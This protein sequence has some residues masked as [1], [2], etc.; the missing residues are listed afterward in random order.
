MTSTPRKRYASRSPENPRYAKR[1]ANSSPEEGEVDDSAPSVPPPPT[2][3]KSVIAPIP[4]PPKPT[5]TGLSVLGAAKKVPFPFKKKIEL[6]ARDGPSNEIQERNVFAKLEEKIEKDDRRAR[7]LKQEEQSRRQQRSPPPLPP[8]VSLLSRI[9]PSADVRYRP[10]WDNRDSRD[11]RDNRDSFN[12]REG[13]YYRPSSPA[14]SPRRNS[15]SPSPHSRGG[16]R[17]RLPPAASPSPPSYRRDRSRERNRDYYD[18]R[19]DEPRGRDYRDRDDRRDDRW[20]SRRDNYDSFDRKMYNSGDSHRYESDRYRSGHRRASPRALSPRS[21]RAT[22]PSPPRRPLSEELPISSLPPRPPSLPPSPP[23]P[24]PAISISK[25]SPPSRSRTPVPPLAP[26]S[27][28]PPADAGPRPPSSTPPPAPPPDTR[29]HPASHLPPPPPG[30]KKPSAPKADHSPKSLDLPPVSTGRAMANGPQMKLSRTNQPPPAKEARPEPARLKKK[31]PLRRPQK[32][33][34]A[35]YGHTFVGCGLQSDYEATTKLGEGT[36]GEVHKAIHKST[37]T[38]VALKRILMHNEKEGMPVTALREIKILKAL[39]HPCIVNILDMFVVRSTEK[40]PLSV[41]MV[42]PYM[43]HDLAGLLENERVKLQPS[44]IKLYMKQLLEGTEYMHR[45]HILHRDMKAANLLISNDGSLRIADFGLARSFDSSPVTTRPDGSIRR[46]RKYTNCVVTRWY[47]PPELLLGARQYGGEVDIWGIGCV[48]GEMFTRRPILPGTS[49]IDQLEKIWY[50]CGSPNQL[51]W[52][53]FDQLP[54]CEGVRRFAN[55][56]RRLKTHYDSIGIPPETVDLLDKLLIINPS[57]RITASQALD[58]DYFWTDPLPADP[59]TMPSYEASHEF[60]KRGHRNQMPPAAVAQI[61]Q[62]NQQQQRNMPGNAA[63]NNNRNNHKGPPPQHFGGPPGGPGDMNRR[64]PPPGAFGVPPPHQLQ[65]HGLPPPPHNMP[66][67]PG[68]GGGFRNGP[69]PYGG[70][71]MHPGGPVPPFMN[72]PPPNPMSGPFGGIGGGGLGGGYG[73]PPFP[74]HP[75]NQFV[76][77]LPHGS[78]PYG[79]MPGN[80][81]G[82][83]GGG[84]RGDRRDGGQRNNYDRMHN[85]NNN[86]NNNQPQRTLPVNPSLPPKPAVPL[87]PMHNERQREREKGGGGGGGGGGGQWGDTGGGWGTGRG[88]PPPPPAD[89]NSGADGVPPGGLN[90]D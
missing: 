9:G 50:L 12:T 64:G 18:R 77:P 48:L 27:P 24:P 21:P 58:H 87:G 29:L 67:G 55:H 5:A 31:L 59:K 66:P 71:P 46:E 70:P 60:D 19:H 79:V 40:D 33:E 6:H 54:G 85:H 78:R 52:P 1:P 72:G 62:A 45:N 84:Q 42:F 15:R 56:P 65:Q 28:P 57:E 86:N 88:R 89:S 68:G 49:D 22:S 80:N 38:V 37:G 75:A 17:H 4:L 90:Y 16:S 2:A 53:Y 63:F 32:V 41:Y 73:G 35:A 74:P 61:H 7:D 39:K 30:L 36:F 13:S 26:N 23:P 11:S 81:R 34:I 25:P 82:G 14:R 44:H 51:N 69:P 20:S 83:G 47:R 43:D 8:T 10:G 3:P 76:P